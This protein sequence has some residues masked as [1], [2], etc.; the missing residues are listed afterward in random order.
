MR[1]NHLI[2]SI[3]SFIS[4]FLAAVCKSQIT[5]ARIRE[6]WR[7]WVRVGDLWQIGPESGRIW[8]SWR[9]WAKVCQSEEISVNLVENHASHYRRRQKRSR[10]FPSAENEDYTPCL[11]HLSLKVFFFC[12]SCK[13]LSW[14]IRLFG[15]WRYKLSTPRY[16]NW[17]GDITEI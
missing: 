1:L 5:S 13:K 8:E 14:R 17:V 4:L 11:R 12:K 9:I 16:K 10:H 15:F 6:C 7:I 2:S 3:L